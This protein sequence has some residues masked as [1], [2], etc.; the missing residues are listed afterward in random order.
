M[1]V[2]FVQNGETKRIKIGSS[3][4]PKSRIS[5]LQTATDCELKLLG[6]IPGDVVVEKQL[7]EEF[8]DHRHR[9]EWFDGAILA[10]IEKLVAEKA[11]YAYRFEQMLRASE[12]QTIFYE[13]TTSNSGGYPYTGYIKRGDLESV[14]P[15]NWRNFL[16]KMRSGESA[17]LGAMCDIAF[18][19]RASKVEECAALW[20]DSYINENGSLLLHNR[21][22]V[23]NFMSVADVD[24]L[25]K[26]KN[27]RLWGHPIKYSFPGNTSVKTVK[28]L[29]TINDLKSGYQLR[30]LLESEMLSSAKSFFDACVPF[31]VSPSSC[32]GSTI[33][34]VALKLEIVALC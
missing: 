28:Q 32:R 9:G 17:T 27:R 31:K 14:T 8:A 2:Y 19:K 34:S 22:H 15:F 7:H 24:A 3:D 25:P 29:S 23:W 18:S 4:K 33:N 20:W 26:I 11:P 12:H 21:K 1:A 6:T 13:L 10:A 30:A 5:N 16:I